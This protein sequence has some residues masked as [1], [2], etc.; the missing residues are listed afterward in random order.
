MKTIHL[1]FILVAAFANA[2]VVITDNDK[3]N[4]SVTPDPSAM[5]EV[6]HDK[7]GVYFPQ[8]ALNNAT[9]VTNVTSPQEGTVVFNTNKNLPETKYE[10]LVVWDGTKWLFSNTEED[11]SKTI[12]VIKNHTYENSAIS[13]ISTFPATTP[14]FSEGSTFDSNVWTTIIED[15]T[16]TSYKYDYDKGVQ[17]L[18]VDAEGIAAVNNTVNSSSFTYAVGIFIDNKLFSVRKFRRISISG[19]CNFHKF[20]IRGVKTNG[21]TRPGGQPYNIK[22]AVAMLPKG[23][24]SYYDTMTF[25]A[26]AVGCSNLNSDTAKTYM[27]ILTIEREL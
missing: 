17:K 5:L 12:D 21:F 4:G 26:A 8:V 20:N 22:L 16:D 9:D 10:G 6:R 19:T 24:N 3:I 18:V 7:K 15:N 11:L 1:L 13:D 2:Q 25:G 23:N 27:N 14:L